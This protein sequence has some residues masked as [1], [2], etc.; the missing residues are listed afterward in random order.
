MGD[1]RTRQTHLAM[2]FT[3]TKR[4]LDYTCVSQSLGYTSAQH[5]FESFAVD[6][7]ITNKS[8]V[9]TSLSA[10]RPQHSIALSSLTTSI[11]RHIGLLTRSRWCFNPL[12]PLLRYRYNTVKHP[13]P[14]SDRVKP[15]FVIFDIRA[16]WRSALSVCFGGKGRLYFIEEKAKV[17]CALCFGH[18]LPN[19]VED[20]NRRLPIG[21]IFQ[22]RA[23]H[24]T[25]CG[26]T[27]FHAVIL[28]SA[29]FSPSVLS[30]VALM[31]QAC[32][33]RISVCLSVCDVTYCG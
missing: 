2:N 8:T 13:V 31:R 25:G 4:L 6:R 1:R 32:V 33:R 14:L 11:T 9:W 24:R 28:T 17:D 16:H 19:L 26:P 3:D 20:C 15:P 5:L 12:T 27:R 30:T 10:S 22:Q 7:T 21:F 29:V 23:A 18:M